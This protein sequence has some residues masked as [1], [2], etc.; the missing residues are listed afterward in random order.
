MSRSSDREFPQRQRRR[1]V[2]AR[3]PQPGSSR[4]IVGVEMG[5]DCALVVAGVHVSDEMGARS[6]LGQHE[7]HTH[8][9]H[10]LLFVAFLGLPCTCVCVCAREC[11]C[12]YAS[13][14]VDV[15]IVSKRDEM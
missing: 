12:V 4:A 2:H 11:V 14:C 8:H 5:H 6:G 7:G 13:E 10:G 3:E 15:V 1:I 9:Q